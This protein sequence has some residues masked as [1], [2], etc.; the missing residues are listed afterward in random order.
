[1]LKVLLV[2]EQAAEPELLKSI[3]PIMRSEDLPLHVRV[4]AVISIKSML[5]YVKPYAVVT[6]PLMKYFKDTKQPELL[7]ISIAAVLMERPTIPIVHALA[8]YLQFER[9]YAVRKFV[10]DV[11]FSTA[12]D[13]LPVHLEV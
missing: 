9:S 2:V 8:H 7:R 1:M 4:Q 5:Q 13:V 6:Q 10:Y 3:L 11:L 12:T